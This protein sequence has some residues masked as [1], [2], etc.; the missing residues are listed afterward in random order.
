MKCLLCESVAVFDRLCVPCGA[1]LWA[2]E[3]W[4]KHP[5]QAHNERMLVVERDNSHFAADYHERANA[6]RESIKGPRDAV[7]FRFT[8]TVAR[9]ARDAPTPTCPECGR[10]TRDEHKPNC[11]RNV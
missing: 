4:E 1:K 8:L 6:L 9:A 3:L 2:C 5:T 11:A 7:A 10:M